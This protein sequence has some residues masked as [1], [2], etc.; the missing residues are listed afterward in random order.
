VSGVACLSTPFLVVRPQ[1]HAGKFG[2]VS[3]VAWWAGAS[4][5]AFFL[6]DD[7]LVAAAIIFPIV[8]ATMGFLLWAHFNRYPEP[9]AMSVPEKFAGSDA[10]DS[11]PR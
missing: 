5:A 8:I 3:M 1:P 10:A 11:L 6:T 9:K 7:D 2:I 4:V